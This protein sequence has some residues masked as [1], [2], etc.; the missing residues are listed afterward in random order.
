VRAR[1]RT[2]AGRQWDVGRRYSELLK[3]VLDERG[4]EVPAPTRT[5]L[6]PQGSP[7]TRRG[8]GPGARDARDAQDA[9]DA[10]P[11]P[12]PEVLDARGARA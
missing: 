6:V 5:I 2:R 12:G 1:I 9:Q 4:I 7:A 10:R 11:E 3:E 8:A